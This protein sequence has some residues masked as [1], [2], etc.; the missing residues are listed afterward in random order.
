MDERDAAL[1][2][3]L[4]ELTVQAGGEPSSAE[5]LDVQLAQLELNRFD[6]P[7]HVARA[8]SEG[9]LAEHNRERHERKLA[10]DR[11]QERAL[12]RTGA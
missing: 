7:D 6:R 2:R 12:E 8:R 11:A 4:S 9:R 10:F 1:L 5:Q 3:L